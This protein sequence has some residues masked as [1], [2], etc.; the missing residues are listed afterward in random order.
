MRHDLPVV[1]PCK[2]GRS[3]EDEEEKKRPAEKTNKKRG[4]ENGV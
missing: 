3:R 4:D 2:E 1:N